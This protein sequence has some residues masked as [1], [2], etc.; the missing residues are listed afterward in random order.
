MSVNMNSCIFYGCEV[1][2]RAAQLINAGAL[3]EDWEEEVER[4]VDLLWDGLS[5]EFLYVGVLLHSVDG[6]SNGEVYEMP[7]FLTNDQLDFNMQVRKNEML[8]LVV[9]DLK[10]KLYHVV[11]WS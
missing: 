6:F 10:P 7:E 11:Y 1:S 5:G 8:R 4:D 3:P 2:E 9:G